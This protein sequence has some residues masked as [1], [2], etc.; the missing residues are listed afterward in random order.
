MLGNFQVASV[1]VRKRAGTALVAAPAWY[2]I[3]QI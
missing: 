1:T 2:I 3:Y